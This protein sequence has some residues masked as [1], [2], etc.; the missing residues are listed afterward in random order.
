MLCPTCSRI[1]S[2]RSIRNAIP[3]SASESLK[4][5]ETHAFMTRFEVENPMLWSAERPNRYVLIAE[6]KDKKGRLLDCTS[7][8]FGI[9]TVE[10]RET[11]AEEDEFKLAGRYFYVND[12]P[13]KLKGVNRHETNPS[14]GHAIT[15]RKGNA[16]PGSS[17]SLTIKR[18]SVVWTR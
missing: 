3:L 13:V 7:T 4:K 16:G 17:T 2:K 9:R 6:L 8:Y 12:K 14:T 10:I 5:G 11:K 15:S 1:R 18:P